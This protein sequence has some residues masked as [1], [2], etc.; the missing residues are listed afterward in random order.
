MA[1][2]SQD[3][4]VQTK[5]GEIDVKLCL[6]IN[7]NINL[8]NGQIQVDATATP[9]PKQKTIEPLV[10]KVAYPIPEFKSHGNIQ[11]GND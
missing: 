10:D 2:Y 7:L 6:E 4:V 5:D 11:F 8:H 3:V 9:L 1:K